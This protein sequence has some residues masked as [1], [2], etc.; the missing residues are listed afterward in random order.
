MMVIRSHKL[1]TTSL[2]RG[3]S[4]ALFFQVVYLHKVSPIEIQFIFI[5]RFVASGWMVVTTFKPWHYSRS[6]GGGQK[7]FWTG[8][9]QG[10]LS[11]QKCGADEIGRRVHARVE[12]F[13]RQ[14]RDCS[15]QKVRDPGLVVVPSL[16]YYKAACNATVGL[17]VVP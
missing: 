14:R 3:E 11:T 6:G 1:Q 5:A 7:D 12:Y 13:L 17:R 15:M 10:F 8:Y 2:S 9:L 4:E 16:C